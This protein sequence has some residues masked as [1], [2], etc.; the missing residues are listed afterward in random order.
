MVG[1]PSSST[2]STSG[3]LPLQALKD[4]MMQTQDI[5]QPQHPLKAEARNLSFY[6]GAVKALKGI[7]MPIHD[8]KVTALIGPSG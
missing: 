3:V 1:L 7:N 4:Y 2:P 5:T 8:K 6:Y